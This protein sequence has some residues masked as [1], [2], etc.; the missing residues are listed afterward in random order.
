MIAYSCWSLL[1]LCE[2]CRC[3]WMCMCVISSS[4]SW[5]FH[6]IRTAGSV[7]VQVKINNMF[8][9]L[10]IQIRDR[11]C[12]QDD[13]MLICND[14]GSVSKTCCW[15]FL[16]CFKN[17]SYS[18]QTQLVPW[19]LYL[20]GST[21]NGTFI[22]FKAIQMIFFFS[23]FVWLAIWIQPRIDIF[24]LAS[25]SAA[26]KIDDLCKI[27]QWPSFTQHN[28]V[29]VCQQTRPSLELQPLTYLTAESSSLTGS[30]PE[31]G[32]HL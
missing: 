32:S 23:Y 11:H 27:K 25:H 3:A 8:C 13:N 31:A 14:V 21:H 10:I 29:F 2:D 19:Q 17:M 12:K 18:V 26:L 16:F 24:P 15:F 6:H 30:D 5:N 20:S 4:V 28:R 1:Q 22:N 9:H 7:V